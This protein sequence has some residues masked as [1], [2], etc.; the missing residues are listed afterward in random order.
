MVP[1]V[2][3]NEMNEGNDL[4][5]DTLNTFYLRLYGARHMVKDHSNSERG[6]LVPPHGLFFQ[7]S[8]TSS[9]ICP[10]PDRIAHTTAFVT[11]VE[12]LWLE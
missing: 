10:I 4:F 1:N 6:N 3:E 2:Y 5:N 8:S 12:D 11:P 9:F 7:I